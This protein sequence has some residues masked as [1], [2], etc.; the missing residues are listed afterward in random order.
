MKKVK[1]GVFGIH[2]GGNMI[3]YCAKADNAEIVAICDKNIT[4]IEQYKRY[5][6]DI[7]ITYYTDFDSFLQHDMDAVVLANYAHQHAPFAIRCLKA[8]KHVFSEVLPVQCMKEAVELIETVEET[9]MTYAYG[10]NY[11]YL[12]ATREMKKLYQSGKLGEFEYAEGEYIHNCEP[13]WH[14]IT[15]GERDHWRNNMTAFYYCTHS[16][17]PILYITGLKPVKVTGFEIPFNDRMA[18]MGAKAGPIGVEMVTLENGAVI[19]SVHGVGVSKN[20]VWYSVYGSKGRMESFREDGSDDG[21]SHLYVNCDKYEGQNDS[22]PYEADTSDDLTEMSA[23]NGHSGS[24]FYTMYHFVDAVRGNK[25][26]DI[27]DRQIEKMFLSSDIDEGKADLTSYDF[28]AHCFV[29]F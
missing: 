27:I 11:C 2:R 25:Y 22:E 29:S 16:L 12:P 14:S 5:Y 7:P 6:K 9:G 18:R 1:I 23:G 24:D 19:K 17:G 26:A 4:L 13:I 10:E 28:S 8:G 20:S 21:V 15:Y 3:K